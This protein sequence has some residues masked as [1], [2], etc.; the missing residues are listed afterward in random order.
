MSTFIHYLQ[1]KG[2]APRTQ[3]DTIRSVTNFCNFCPKENINVTKKDI[4]LY[5]EYQQ[6]LGKQKT[7]V[8]IYLRHLRYYFDYLLQNKQVATNPTNFIKIRGLKRRVLQPVFTAEE[9][10]QLADTYYQN[11]IINFD[12]QT[13]P[14]SIQQYI[15]ISRQ[16]NYVLLTFLLYQGIQTH[17]LVKMCVEDI[18]LIKATVKIPA[19]KRTNARTLTLKASQ[20]GILLHYTQQVRPTLLQN[21][22]QDTNQLFLQTAKGNTKIKPNQKYGNV[23]EQ[24]KQQLQTIYPNLV[25]LRQLRTSVITHYIQTQGLRKAQYLAGHRYISSTENYLP[26]DIKKL[27]TQIQEY[28]PF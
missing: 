25:H 1:Q 15:I 8:N 18:D 22:T 24:L 10:T 21:Y 17:E 2:F 3:N 7:T 9:L 14:K 6:E 13:V 5:I 19:T 4:L 26:N 12:I 16:R 27:S 11:F 20:I 28:N 23:F